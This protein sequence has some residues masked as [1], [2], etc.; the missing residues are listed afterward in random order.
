MR[1]DAVTTDVLLHRLSAHNDTDGCQ[2]CLD[3]SVGVPQGVELSDPSVVGCESRPHSCGSD[4]GDEV[5]EIHVCAETLLKQ[6]L[7]TVC[8]S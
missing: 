2:P 5:V 7:A 3:L 4:S 1:S 6:E 8:V